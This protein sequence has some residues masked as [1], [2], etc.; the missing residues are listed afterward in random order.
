MNRHNDKLQEILRIVRSGRDFFVDAYANLTDAQLRTTFTYLT[1]VKSQF[2]VDVAPW[3]SSSLVG[4]IDSGSRAVAIER[5]Y[6][7]ARSNFRGEKIVA[8]ASELGFAEAQLL[9]LVEQAYEATT[10]IKLKRLLKAYYPQFIICR[11]A[12]WRLSARCAA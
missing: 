1:D 11:E 4:S 3:T 9:R 5:I 8:S 12:M 7:D 10:D 6:A 2:I